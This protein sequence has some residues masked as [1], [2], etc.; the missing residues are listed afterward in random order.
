[1]VSGNIQLAAIMVILV[2]WQKLLIVVLST[3]FLGLLFV[4]CRKLLSGGELGARV[5]LWP[6]LGYAALINLVVCDRLIRMY[7]G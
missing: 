6:F 3:S 1:M 2:G 5:P 4:L 7:L